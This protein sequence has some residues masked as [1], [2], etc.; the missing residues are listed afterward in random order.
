MRRG[1][2]ALSLSDVWLVPNLSFCTSASVVLLSPRSPSLFSWNI[3]PTTPSRACR[4]PFAPFSLLTREY[5]QGIATV[6]CQLRQ[7]NTIPASAF[8]ESGIMGIDYLDLIDGRGGNAEAVRES[9]RR[10]ND[11]VELVDEC[12]G[13]YEAWNKR[14]C[15]HNC[16]AIPSGMEA[17]MLC[18]ES[19][20]LMRIRRL[21][22]C[23]TTSQSNSRWN[24]SGRTST[25]CKSQSR[26][27]RRCVASHCSLPW[28]LVVGCCS[29]T[30][31]CQEMLP[32]LAKTAQACILVPLADCHIL[33]YRNRQ[34]RTPPNS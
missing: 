6:I 10:R 31:A 29:R 15:K 19:E 24:R 27:R 16:Y 28:T 17:V 5:V 3:H 18:S 9:Q 8:R 33:A 13:M 4:V 14:G 32:C 7:D 22:P 11:S 1:E 26:K 30:G 21:P 20:E 34:S 2:A 25:H 12:I 23:A